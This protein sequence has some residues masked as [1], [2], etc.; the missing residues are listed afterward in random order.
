MINLLPP[1]TRD[2][3]MYARRNTRLLHWIFAILVGIAGLA[4]VVAFGYFYIHQN[5]QNVTRQ[6]ELSKQELKDQK[7]DE[8]QKQV[9]EISNNF[10]LVQ[11]VLSKQ[12]LFSGLIKQ[13]GAA[14]PAGTQLSSL[15]LNKPQGGLDLQIASTNYQTATQVQVNLQDPANKIFEKVDIISVNCNPAPQNKYACV[16]TYRALFAKENPF[17]LLNSGGGI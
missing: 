5:I 3:I 12:I 17:Y 14:M 13:I 11:Q 16:G 4:L 10:K 15:S 6:V 2:D 9:E 8:T 7:L 1:Q